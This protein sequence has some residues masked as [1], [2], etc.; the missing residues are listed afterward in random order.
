MQAFAHSA[1]IGSRAAC[2]Q[3]PMHPAV[4]CRHDIDDAMPENDQ[5]EE[6][7]QPEEG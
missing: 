4:T 6:P 1:L 7:D 3:A 2:E 5:N